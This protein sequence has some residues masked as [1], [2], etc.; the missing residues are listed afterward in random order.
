MALGLAD[1][2]EFITRPFRSV[3]G[4]I[5]LLAVAAYIWAR[6]TGKITFKRDQGGGGRGGE[7]RS[8]A[9]YTIK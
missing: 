2:G 3:T 5:F 9:D 7:T 1:F 8:K 6:V 4:W